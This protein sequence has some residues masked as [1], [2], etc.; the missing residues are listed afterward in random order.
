MTNTWSDLLQSRKKQC[1]FISFCVFK[2]FE[3]HY[4][5]FVYVSKNLLTRSSFV[6]DL[7]CLYIYYFY[8]NLIAYNYVLSIKVFLLCKTHSLEYNFYEFVNYLNIIN[9]NM[10]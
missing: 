5:L 3:K 7:I 2:I 1:N 9:C 6:F 4:L 10:F 8:A